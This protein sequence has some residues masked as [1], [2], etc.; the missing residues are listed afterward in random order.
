MANIVS[1]EVIATKIFE[2]RG[3]KV[4]LGSELAKLYNVQ[5]KHLTRQV[6]R[7]IK[8][9]PSDFMIQL[10]Q[11]E[12]QEI[13][14]CQIGTLERGKYSKYLPY[15][16]TEQGVAM[17]SSVLNSDRAIRVNIQ[18]M[19]AFVQIRKMLITNADL[20]RKIEAIEKKYDKQFA[21][22][23]QALK[24]LLEP[25]KQTQAIGFHIHRK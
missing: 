12:Y 16:F 10:T 18:I 1:V 7:N 20:R 6:R 5:T 21:I 14:R 13:L 4:M 17:L 11:K 23:F 22:V 25:P 19:R 2:V 15:A 8:R 3:K 24:Q 9:F